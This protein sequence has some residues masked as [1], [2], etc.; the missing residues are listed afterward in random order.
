MI[1]YLNDDQLR[2]DIKPTSR[3]RGIEPFK[4]GEKRVTH[5]D[6]PLN[7]MFDFIKQIVV[8]RTLFCTY[9]SRSQYRRKLVCFCMKLVLLLFGSTTFSILMVVQELTCELLVC[10]FFDCVMNSIRFSY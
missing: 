8:S 2:D 4:N 9:A 10:K 6:I 3:C 7:Y 5:P 1:N